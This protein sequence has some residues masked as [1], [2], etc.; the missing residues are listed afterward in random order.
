VYHNNKL[1]KMQVILTNDWHKDNNIFAHPL[2]R[3]YTITL[4]FTMQP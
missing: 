1:Y 2:S 3:S 4:Y